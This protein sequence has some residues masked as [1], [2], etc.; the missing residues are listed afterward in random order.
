[1]TTTAEAI[2]DRILD[3]LEALT[4]RALSEYAFLRHQEDGDGDFVTWVETYPQSCLRRVHVRQVSDEGPETTAGDVAWV[5][6]MFEIAIAYPHS[7]AYGTDSGLDRD[8]VI[9]QDTDQIKHAVGEWGAGRFVSPYPEATW[10]GG[11]ESV[12]IVNGADVL[13]IRQTM[14]FWQ[15]LSP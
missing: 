3:V 15:D 5:R 12:A 11:D 1:M 9:E 10:E 7:N 2:R 4:P 6:V 13:I 8:D 14:G